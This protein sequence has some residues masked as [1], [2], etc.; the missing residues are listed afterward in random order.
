MHQ[1]VRV[2]GSEADPCLVW[3]SEASNKFFCAHLSAA[4]NYQ[5]HEKRRGI[6]VD[7]PTWQQ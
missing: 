1:I 2:V 6:R 3:E 7:N 4:K 5:M